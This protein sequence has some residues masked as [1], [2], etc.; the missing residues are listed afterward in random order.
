MTGTITLNIGQMH[1]RGDYGCKQINFCIH[2]ENFSY[3]KL[4]VIRNSSGVCNDWEIYEEV[5]CSNDCRLYGNL[6]LQAA[7]QHMIDIFKLATG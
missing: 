5:P 7:K 1:T 6:T 3:Y 4:Y 2:S